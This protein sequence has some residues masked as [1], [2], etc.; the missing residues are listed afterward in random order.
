MKRKSN[1][2]FKFLFNKK[3]LNSKR[4]Q[5]AIEFIILVGFI[6]FFFTTFFLAIQGNISD[7]LEERKTLRIKEIA[8]A[9]Q[10][11]INLASQSS[12][13]YYR[14]FK[15]PND[16]S[17]QDYEVE[18]IEEMV[19]VK[20]QDGKHAIALPVQNVTGQIEKPDNIIKK[21]NG[22]VKLNE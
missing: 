2:H 5:S 22:V 20:T 21:E 11:E 19:Y 16:I 18:I 1:S 10:D 8:L 4:S 12:E 13:G 17:G 6:L 3:I 9:V 14:E 7:K 15:I